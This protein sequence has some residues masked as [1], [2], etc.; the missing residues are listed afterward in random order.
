MGTP[1]GRAIDRF[2]AKVE[3][4]ENGCWLWTAY[5][6]PKGYGKFGFG[7]G[8]RVVMAHR[9][10]YG[11]FVGPIPVEHE[12]DHL[13]RVRSCVNPDHLE[14]VTHRVNLLR[15]D[16]VTA[17]HAATTHCPKG[18]PYDDVNTAVYDGSRQCRACRRKAAA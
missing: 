7:G 11:H 13:C 6:N 12:I 14:A 3:V 10:A 16:T 9:W 2:M 1:H 5:R 18:H 17:K 15:G 4:D 8:N